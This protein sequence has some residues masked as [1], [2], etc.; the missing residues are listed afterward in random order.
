MK[1]L[2]YLHLLIPRLSSAPK[3]DQPHRTGPLS[4]PRL[5]QTS[6]IIYIFNHLTL[7]PVENADFDA[8]VDAGI[9]SKALAILETI[10]NL[11]VVLD[12]HFNISKLSI[13]NSIKANSHSK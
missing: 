5:P 1:L 4:I 7:L 11:I 8:T 13:S 3:D 6:L 10:G 12:Y 2:P 9:D